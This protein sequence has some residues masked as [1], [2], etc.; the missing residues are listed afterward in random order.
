MSPERLT[1]D[2]TVARDFLDAARP[3]HAAILGPAVAVL[4]TDAVGLLLHHFYRLDRRHHAKRRVG[5]VRVVLEAPVLKSQ[6]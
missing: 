1:I 3:R 2:L 4:F 5:T 6:L